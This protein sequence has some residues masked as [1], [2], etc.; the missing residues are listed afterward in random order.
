MCSQSETDAISS[1]GMGE[2]NWKLLCYEKPE[3]HGALEGEAE[4]FV[5]WGTTLFQSY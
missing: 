2:W 3:L 5:L 4:V 1:T